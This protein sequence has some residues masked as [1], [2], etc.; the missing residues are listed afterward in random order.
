MEEKEIPSSIATLLL[1]SYDT[2]TGQT[3]AQRVG[4]LESAALRF[5]GV[6]ERRWSRRIE[7]QTPGSVSGWTELA[8]RPWCEDCNQTPSLA[9]VC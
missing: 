5:A 6:G 7:Q 3:S 1:L 8:L 4:G 9:Y 2:L